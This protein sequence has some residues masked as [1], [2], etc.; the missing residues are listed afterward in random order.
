MINKN[1]DA[2]QIKRGFITTNKYGGSRKK[3]EGG[4]GGWWGLKIT[5]QKQ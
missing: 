5:G 2:I 3:G 4:G 1:L